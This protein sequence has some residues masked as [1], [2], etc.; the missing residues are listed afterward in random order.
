MS[1]TPEA[2]TLTPEAPSVVSWKERLADRP[3]EYLMNITVNSSA[4][5][6]ASHRYACE[7]LLNERMGWPTPDEI[8]YGNAPLQRDYGAPELNEK[9]RRLRDTLPHDVGDHLFNAM[10]EEYGEEDTIHAQCILGDHGLAIV[11]DYLKAEQARLIYRE[12]RAA[13]ALFKAEAAD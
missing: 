13:A 6:D 12:G 11:E 4:E 10:I 9:V 3:N 5:V 2:V 7:L 1:A 8:K